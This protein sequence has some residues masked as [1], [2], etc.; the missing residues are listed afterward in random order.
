MGQP[1]YRNRNRFR[2]YRH[3][4][5]KA[6]QQYPLGTDHWDAHRSRQLSVVLASTHT[7]TKETPSGVDSCLSPP[8]TQH[9]VHIPSQSHHIPPHH[10]TLVPSAMRL[11]CAATLLQAIVAPL[12]VSSFRNDMVRSITPHLSLLCLQSRARPFLCYPLS[13]PGSVCSPGQLSSP[14]PPFQSAF[15]CR[16]VNSLLL[17]LLAWLLAPCSSHPS[18]QK[19]L[20]RQVRW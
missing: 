20:S 7:N 2:F 18:N 16:A 4:S 1:R 9:Y 5:T 8:P 19:C 13:L 17:C 15:S 11:G 10:L 3:K 12:S 6:P 14:P